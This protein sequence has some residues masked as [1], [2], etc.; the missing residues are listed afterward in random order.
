MPELYQALPPLE[1]APTPPPVEAVREPEEKEKER[2]KPPRRLAEAWREMLAQPGILKY[3]VGAGVVVA[4]TVVVVLAVQPFL[5]KS[6][7]RPTGVAQVSPTS[8]SRATEVTVVTPAATPTPSH[9]PRAPTTTLLPSTPAPT[10]IMDIASVQAT[11]TVA[12]APPDMV[13]VPAGE[14][15]MGS[16]EGE[17]EDDEHPQ[18]TVYLDAFYIGKYEVTNAEYKECVDAGACDPPSE[19]WSSTRD[20]YYGNPEYD[21]YPVIHV[22][23]YDAQAY[24]EWKGQRLPTE[25]E[26]EKAARGTD[27][28][29]YPWDNEFGKNKCNTS[30]SGINDTTEVGS[31]PDGVS[32][33]GAMDMAGN[34]WEWVA[35]WQDGDYYSK[36]TERNPP[37]PDSG[38]YRVLRGGSWSDDQGFARCSFRLGYVPNLRNDHFGFRVAASPGS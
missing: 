27:G 36:A 6:Q 4:L 33:Y 13:F 11:Q 2:P 5:P 9:T 24:C 38:E 14:F 26:W 17:G 21:N 35:D 1:P 32:P 8:T 3:L 30:E 7:P 29:E 10:P 23:W 15:I 16:P 20:P 22:S 19:S 12:S 28:R 37:G 18:R 34:V 25:A 31:Y